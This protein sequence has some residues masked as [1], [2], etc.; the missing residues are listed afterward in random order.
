MCVLSSIMFLVAADMLT[1][2]MNVSYAPN[3]HML[4]DHVP[5]A[6]LKMNGFFDMGEDAIERWH[7]IRM[8]HHA[9]I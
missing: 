2:E 5:D 6:L 4:C 3:F 1:H 8:R 7:Q 9:R